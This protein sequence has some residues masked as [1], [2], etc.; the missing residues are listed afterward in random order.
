[1][2]DDVPN[3][4]NLDVA[5]GT[6]IPEY[7]IEAPYHPGESYPE[8]KFNEVSTI[9]NHPYKLFRKLLFDLGY[10][11][12]NFGKQTWN[13]FGS[14]IKEGDSVVIKPN[15]VLSYNGSG[16]SIFSVVTHPS[17]L[18]VVIDYSFIA[19]NGKGRITIADAPQMDCL[20]SDLMAVQR[21]DTIQEFYKKKFNFEVELY[22]LRNFEL[23][24]NYQKAY[25]GNRRQLNGDPLG[26]AIINLGKDSAFYGMPSH[27]YYGADI[28]RDETIK[29]HHGDIHE[30]SVSKTI[31]SADVIISVPKMKVHKKVG[32]TL[33][34]KGLVGI[35]TNKNYLVH[36]RVGTKKVGGD[37]LPELESAYDRFLIKT[38]RMLYDK[39]LSKMSKV[40]DLVYKVAL[41]LYNTFLK[42]FKEVST[43]T[44][45]RD[46]GNW[47]GNDSAWRMTSDLVKILYFANSDGLM[48]KEVQR[49]IF[50]IIDGIVAGDNN[51][52]LAPHD[53]KAGCLIIG[54]NPFAVD[55]VATRLMDFDINKIR[56]FDII[57]YKEWN[58]SINDPAQI[59]VIHDNLSE[60]GEEFFSS[61]N[62]SKYF[63][64]KPHPGWV[65]TIEI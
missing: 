50:C 10:D 18:R 47:H 16:N 60:S 7:N 14:I 36:Y 19:I 32:V 56:Q 2:Q 26:S 46:G 35:N 43:S 13:P 24:D 23:I 49:K 61:T 12:Q 51:G 37:Q 21:I 65:G 58:F 52:P 25:H 59:N 57:K 5:Y 38:Q 31:L 11:K 41:G 20:W 27:N 4:A 28:N 34:L 40:G 33:N 6:T 54:A 30:Y 9:P 1:M 44:V 48:E 39:A 42:P 45:V 22:D 55:M 64:F 62:T 63:G 15:Y 3:I 17:I 8:S 29:H 53:K